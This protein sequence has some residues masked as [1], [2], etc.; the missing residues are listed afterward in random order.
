VDL[1]DYVAGLLAVVFNA[2]MQP[3]SLPT[4]YLLETSILHLA[5]YVNTRSLSPIQ[6]C[7]HLFSISRYIDKPFVNIRKDPMGTFRVISDKLLLLQN[8]NRSDVE[9]EIEMFRNSG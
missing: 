6:N 5:P 4:T 1:S 2:C 9:D 8:K 7:I 3:R